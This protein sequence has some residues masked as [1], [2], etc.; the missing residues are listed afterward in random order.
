MKKKILGLSLVAVP[1]ISFAATEGIEGIIDT[2]TELLG[3]VMPL[4][5]SLAVI[6]FVYAL[7]KYVLK[8]GEEKEEARGQMIW[9]VVIL[10]VM[11]SV[12][13]LV[14]LLK[15]SADL[16]NTVPDVEWVVTS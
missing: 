13:G 6:F 8:A 3:L 15:D 4:L 16:D 1:M 10:F 9:G 12:W 11:I 7:L 14:N 5:L 2:I